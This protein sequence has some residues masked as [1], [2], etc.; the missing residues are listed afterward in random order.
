MRNSRKRPSA[1]QQELSLFDPISKHTHPGSDESAGLP[2]VQREQTPLES[3]HSEG[4]SHR[5]S[6]GAPQGIRDPRADTG[7]GGRPALTRDAGKPTEVP[8]PAPDLDA[9]VAPEGRNAAM[10]H[11]SIVLPNSR[12]L[13]P[14]CSSSEQDAAHT[15]C[16]LT[17]SVW[18]D[19]LPVLRQFRRQADALEPDAGADTSAAA[20]GVPRDVA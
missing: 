5:N 13:S 3:H 2:V 6:A 9:Q 14:S 20:G 17:P 12:I 1:A 19:L 10:A 18:H 8:P 11:P 16:V 15:Q 4:F 7:G